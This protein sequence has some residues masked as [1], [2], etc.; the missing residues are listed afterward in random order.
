MIGFSVM[1]GLRDDMTA[2]LRQ[3]MDSENITA[4]NL[5]DQGTEL[6][7]RVNELHGSEYSETTLP[8]LRALVFDAGWAYI[9]EKESQQPSA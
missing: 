7:R 5:P 1:L 9:R 6:A 3:L 8:E 4:A 2:T